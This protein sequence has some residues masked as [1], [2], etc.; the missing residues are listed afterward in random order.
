MKNE[1]A[2]VNKLASKLTET[3]PDRPT[4]K[5]ELTCRDCELEASTSAGFN[6]K[7]SSCKNSVMPGHVDV[8]VSSCAVLST[9]RSIHSMNFIP[10]H[11]DATVSS[12]ML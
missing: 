9:L 10:I 1:R 7:N 6:S 11:D 3:R 2:I 5:T 12:S 4:F 8:A